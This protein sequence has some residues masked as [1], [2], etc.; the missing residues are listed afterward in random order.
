MQAV[1]WNDVEELEEAQA[2][3]DAWA[4]LGFDDALCLLTP[5]PSPVETPGAVAILRP[6]PPPVWYYAVSRLEATS[7]DDATLSLYLLQ[8]TLALR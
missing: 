7:T 1:D 3:L 2:L 8:L 4:P 5:T 6:P